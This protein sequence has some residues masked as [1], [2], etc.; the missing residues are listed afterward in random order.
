MWVSIEGRGSAGFAAGPETGSGTPVI[1]VVLTRL[2]EGLHDPANGGTVLDDWQ[3]DGAL[4]SRFCQSPER[5]V[6]IGRMRVL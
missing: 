2:P 1:P 3:A 6:A 4:A 5:R